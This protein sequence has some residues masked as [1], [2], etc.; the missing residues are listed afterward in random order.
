MNS[1]SKFFCL[2]LCVV[3]G[4]LQVLATNSDCSNINDLKIKGDYT[5]AILVLKKCLEENPADND[6]RVSLVEFYFLKGQTEDAKNEIDILKNNGVSEA[7]MNA[8]FCIANHKNKNYKLACQYGRSASSDLL[9][10]SDLILFKN[11]FGQ[12]LFKTNLFVESIKILEEYTTLKQDDAEAWMSLGYAYNSIENYKKALNCFVRGAEFDAK[13]PKKQILLAEAYYDA[14]DRI[15]SLDAYRKAEELGHEKD[16]VFY[17]NVANVFFDLKDYPNVLVLTAEAKKLSPYD[18]DVAYLE[19]YSYYNMDKLKEARAVA[20][21]VLKINP[22]NANFVYFIGMTYQKASQM[23]KA[24]AYFEK[25][26][27]MKPDLEKLRSSNFNWD[28]RKQ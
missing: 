3:L 10:T 27:K 11:S 21:E 5:K 1:F 2:S 20:E 25:A 28:G 16:I 22:E 8:K 19:A 6:L 18:T 17:V 13:N 7:S 12:S 9:S 24:E 14:G 23:N 15:N 4:N 26:I